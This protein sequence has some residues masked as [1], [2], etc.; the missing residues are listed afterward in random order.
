MPFHHQGF[1]T[2]FS[3]NTVN[4]K[5]RNFVGKTGLFLPLRRPG[6]QNEQLAGTQTGKGW[7]RCPGGISC[8]AG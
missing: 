4:G 6:H 2:E 1:A 5:T 7:R 3:A 8:S